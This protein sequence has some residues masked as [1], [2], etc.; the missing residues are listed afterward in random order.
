MAKAKVPYNFIADKLNIKR[1]LYNPNPKQTIR[2]KEDRLD[3]CIRTLCKI[4]NKP[5]KEIHRDIA[6]LCIERGRMEGSLK[7]FEEYL[8]KALLWQEMPEKYYSKYQN[9]AEF[10]YNERRGSFIIRSAEHVAP[11]I[12][13]VWY[14]SRYCLECASS[15]MYHESFC[16]YAAQEYILQLE[17]NEKKKTTK[18]E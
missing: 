7:I 1:E 13:G 17:Y 8:N 18:G 2:S 10:M 4:T 9:I 5:W 15:F 12:N 6:E 3:C 16:V 14:D 11:Y